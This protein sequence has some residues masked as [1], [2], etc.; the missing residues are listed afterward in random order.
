MWE[1]LPLEQ[2]AEY[3]PWNKYPN[4]EEKSYRMG[5]GF[6]RMLQ[7]VN[8]DIIKDISRLKVNKNICTFFPSFLNLSATFDIYSKF[9]V[10]EITS[11]SAIDFFS[12]LIKFIS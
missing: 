11:T 5:H 2:K 3:V 8:E 9:S 4:R 7:M 6:S 10:I 12:A 1:S